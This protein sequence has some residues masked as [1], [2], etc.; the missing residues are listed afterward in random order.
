M[1]TTPEGASMAGRGPRNYLNLNPVNDDGSL[2]AL[3]AEFAR[4][5]QAEIMKRGWSQSDLARQAA[6]HLP[7]NKRMGRD[8]ISTYIRGHAIPRPDKLAAIC[9]A[10]GVEP[11]YL[12]PEG[13]RRSADE[14]APTKPEFRHNDDGTIYVRVNQSLPG[15]LALEIQAKI[16][17]YNHPEKDEE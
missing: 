2:Q 14:R 12:V 15:P 6:L 17:A 10:L 3:R 8:D 7:K 13:A 5:L 1:D 4:R 16:Y 9:A 11:G